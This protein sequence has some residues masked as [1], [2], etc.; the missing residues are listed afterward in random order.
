MSHSRH[1]E[2]PPGASG[3]NWRRLKTAP[4]LFGVH[5]TAP[6]NWVVEAKAQRLLGHPKLREGAEQLALDGLITSGHRRVLSGTSLE[7]QLFMT[8]DIDTRHAVLPAQPIPGGESMAQRT[9]LYHRARSAMLTYLTVR[10]AALAGQAT[11]VPVGLDESLTWW[12]ASQIS[13]LETDD[14]TREVGAMVARTTEDRRAGMA[15]STG[16]DMLA[17]RIPG[18]GLTVGMSRKLYAACEALFGRLTEIA[19]TWDEHAYVLQLEREEADEVT[20]AER[21]LD[22]D[23]AV[24]NEFTQFR[25]R[26]H[27]RRG[28]LIEVAHERYDDASGQEWREIL[29]LPVLPRVEVEPST[30]QIECATSDLYLAV[31][32]TALPPHL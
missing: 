6:H 21:D 17:A 2:I 23:Y 12:E 8:V 18:T 4:D 29:G 20:L 28:E 30:G 15:W 19:P 10:T 27:E 1:S 14:E 13:R 3:P 24:E 7:R 22:T 26:E 31:D 5:P 16:I 25:Q 32:E 11:I 9:D